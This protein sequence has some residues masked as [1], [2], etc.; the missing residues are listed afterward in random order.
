M[1]ISLWE[2]L[3]DNP[4]LCIFVFTF[5]AMSGILILMILADWITGMFEDD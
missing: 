5:L 2:S 3:E 1:M 4:A